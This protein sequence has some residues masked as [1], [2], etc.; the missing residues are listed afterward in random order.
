MDLPNPNI[1]SITI[2]T[3]K[4]VGRSTSRY[5]LAF[6]PLLLDGL[7]HLLPGDF[8][9]VIV[10][11]QQVI[12]QFHVNVVNTFEPIQ[13]IFDPIGS[14]KSGE[15]EAFGHLR[16]MKRHGRLFRIAG[17]AGPRIGVLFVRRSLF[18]AGILIGIGAWAATNQQ[19]AT[20]NTKQE[21]NRS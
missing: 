11:D 7:Q 9:L 18:G 10:N 13:G 2:P 12:K 15:L 19:C 4:R 21:T 8:G 6:K 1:D 17:V 16:H 20:I 5:N 3:N 14:A